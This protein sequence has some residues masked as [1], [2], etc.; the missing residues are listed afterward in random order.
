[1]DKELERM[2]DLS[3]ALLKQLFEQ[4]KAKKGTPDFS[5]SRLKKIRKTMTQLDQNYKM[6]AEGMESALSSGG[7]PQQQGDIL[8]G[9]IRGIEEEALEAMKLL[10]D[11]SVHHI[12]GSRTGGDT[13]IEAPGDRVR[14]VMARLEDEF[15]MS[16]SNS[17]GPDGNL[18]ADMSLSN[19]A[20][21][22]DQRAR[23]LE[24][25]S[26]IG[27][28]PTKSTVAHRSST[29][30][31][32]KNLTPQQLADDDALFEALRSNFQKQID[33]ANIGQATDAARQ[34]LVRELSGDAL[35]YSPDATPEQVAASSKALS[36][37]SDADIITTYQKGFNA[38]DSI[39]QGVKAKRI[40]N[41]RKVAGMSAAAG[42]AGISILGTGASAAETKTR[43]EIAA[44]TGYIADKIQ[45]SISGVSLAADVAS[46]NPL[47][48]IPGA[49]VS[50]GADLTNI[51]IDQF[52]SGATHQRIRGRSG[53]QRAL[54]QP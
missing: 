48:A 27:K 19:R 4:E 54:Q 3:R 22:W 17:V 53:A 32:A 40:Q 37:V 34:R 11:D 29:A 28:E 23:G 45:A 21:K 51:I 18:R 16:F 25:E 42:L 47:A 43:T 12:I 50:T 24:K 7:T 9:S 49:V 30:G 6:Y 41:M 13:L 39:R 5:D 38:I 46:Y 20:H 52:R 26:G 35:A 8:R 14:R 10:Q 44:E 31:H 36:N 33:D 1:M 2:H 15:E